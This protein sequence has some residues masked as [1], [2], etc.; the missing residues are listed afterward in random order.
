[1]IETIY[2]YL[3]ASNRK[4]IRNWILSSDKLKS[5]NTE[6]LSKNTDRSAFAITY[7]SND[8]PTPLKPFSVE[9]YNTCNVICIITYNAGDI[10]LHTDGDL[11]DHMISK[12]IPGF[13]IKDPAMTSVYYV[14]I[15]ENMK[16]GLLKI[17]G[18]FIQPVNDLLIRF[19]GDVAHEVTSVERCN[20]PRMT[21][22][23]EHY[24]LMPGCFKYFDL[25]KFRE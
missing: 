11:K 23:C 10:P 2:N 16:G 5:F 7:C 1:M 15:C 24:K 18:R 8:L 21:L 20:K 3:G 4:A 14:D 22:V 13:Y 6:T 19:P 12:N 9:E 17:Q 25:N